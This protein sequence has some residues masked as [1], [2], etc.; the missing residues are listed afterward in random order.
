M[1]SENK[2]FL[3]AKGIARGTITGEGKTRNGYIR[4]ED[5]EEVYSNAEAGRS[6][7]NSLRA[8]GYIALI[9]EYTGIFKILK[10]PKESFLMA[11]NMRKEKNKLE[12]ESIESDNE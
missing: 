7:L 12:Q 4:A 3:L 2:L 8:W 6:A 5:A 10:A 9:P 11:E 1:L